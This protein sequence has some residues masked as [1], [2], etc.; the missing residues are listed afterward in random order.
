MLCMPP[1]CEQYTVQFVNQNAENG[2][3]KEGKDIDLTSL[4]LVDVTIDCK[5]H[6]VLEKHVSF[7][8]KLI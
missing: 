8:G 7:P 4:S 2:K 3:T 6:H 1:L 5:A